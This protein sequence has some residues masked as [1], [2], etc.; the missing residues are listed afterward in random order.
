MRSLTWITLAIFSKLIA[1]SRDSHS[2]GKTTGQTPSSAPHT[3]RHPQTQ[4]LRSFPHPL[5]SRF[6][7]T[8]PPNKR[9]LDR[10]K[11]TLCGF[12]FSWTDSHHHLKVCRPSTSSTTT[13]T[14]T[15]CHV[16]PNPT[17][18]QMIKLGRRTKTESPL[19]PN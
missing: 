10:S 2:R 19:N 18:N 11:T 17:D 9:R 5:I 16:H 14:T 12:V 1:L 13:H 8:P 15:T 3:I 7:Q 6:I 4:S